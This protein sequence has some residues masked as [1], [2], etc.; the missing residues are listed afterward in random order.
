M[1]MSPVLPIVLALATAAPA[2]ADTCP[3]VTGDQAAAEVRTSFDKWNEAV[4][5]K[6]L[7]ETMAIFSQNIHF[8]FQG[9]P[10]FGFARLNEIYASSFARENS[11]VWHPI[12]ENVIASP[13]MVTLFNEWKLIPAGGGAPL[14]E[15]RGVDVFQREA[16]CV[17]RVTASLNYA[18]RSVAAVGPNTRDGSMG[19]AEVDAGRSHHPLIAARDPKR[20]PIH[21]GPR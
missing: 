12:V 16:D 8:Q 6:D 15:Y 9:S 5:R 21:G 1:R 19:P 10:D 7:D 4:M 3:A 14:K 13:D 11:P 20:P 2:L 17:W 18:D